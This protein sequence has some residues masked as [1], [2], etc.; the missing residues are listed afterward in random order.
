MCVCIKQKLRKTVCVCVCKA[1]IEEEVTNLMGWGEGYRK[2]WIGRGR[3]DVDTVLLY[4]HE[5]F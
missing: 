4:F 5:Q 3:N 1:I 2:S